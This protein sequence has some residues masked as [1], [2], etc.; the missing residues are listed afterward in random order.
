[1]WTSLNRDDL[2]RAQDEMRQR[3]L[4]MDA[5]HTEELKSLE[6]KHAE[7]RDNLEAK[8]TRFDELERL[9]DAFVEEYLQTARGDGST[10]PPR[11][12]AAAP[13]MAPVANPEPVEVEV[14]STN[15][16]NARFKPAEAIADSKPD[17]DLG[18]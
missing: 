18:E 12:E 11:V 7:E 6:V 15:W 5:R 2:R 9:I 14:I 4:E 16:G 10:E 3:H 17:K 13:T 1:M 8:R